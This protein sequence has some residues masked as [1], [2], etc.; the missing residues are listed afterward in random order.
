LIRATSSCADDNS[1]P[2]SDHLHNW[3]DFWDAKLGLP[4]GGKT[5]DL[6]GESYLK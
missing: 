4:V 2:I 6:D 1:L 3:Y 5:A